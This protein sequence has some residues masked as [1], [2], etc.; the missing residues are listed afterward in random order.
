LTN[1]QV[2]RAKED[3]QIVVFDDTKISKTV[4]P[5]NEPV[6]D[7]KVETVSPEKPVINPEKQLPKAVSNATFTFDPNEPQFVVMLLKNVD[8]VYSSEAR[9]AF[10]R[11]NR[12][13]FGS[14]DIEVLKDTLDKERTLLIFSQ[15]I[16]AEAAIRY[17]ETIKRDAASEVSWLPANKYSFFI[18]SNANLGILKDTKELEN[19]LDLIKTKFPGKF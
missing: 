1:L 3:S 2:E 9:N 10:T 12:Q 16:N 17:Q 18:I 14:L 15:F 8:P 4:T 7:E 6:R 13:K 11:Y 19:Y 5:V